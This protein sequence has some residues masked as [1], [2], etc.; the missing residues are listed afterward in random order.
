MLPFMVVSSNVWSDLN[1]KLKIYNW[2]I[3]KILKNVHIL[4]MNVEMS[5]SFI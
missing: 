4:C 1:F 2:K 5:V 3:T